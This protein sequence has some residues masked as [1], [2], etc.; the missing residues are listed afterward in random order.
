LF[1]DDPAVFTFSIHQEHLYPV[2]EPG[3]LD[4]GLENGAGDEEFN[5]QLAG[6]LRRVW[7][8]RPDIVLYQAG[9]DPYEDDQ[10]GALRLTIEGLLARDRLVLEGCAEHGIPAVVTLGGGYA[11]R[12]SDTVRIH[13]N[14]CELAMELAS[15]AEAGPRGACGDDGAR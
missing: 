7:E 13:Q 12:V 4:I 15:G 1:R 8:H 6:A 5:R 3:N 9:A 2:K 14:T 11:R 10:L